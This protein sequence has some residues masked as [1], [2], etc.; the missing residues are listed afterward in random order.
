MTTETIAS[1]ELM[2]KLIE[3]LEDATK[4]T[5]ESAL[6]LETA[7]RI[8]LREKMR[9]DWHG[10]FISLSGDEM[11]LQ[12]GIASDE[13]GCQAIAG[14]LMMLEPDDDPLPDDDLAD[15]F[16]EVANLLLGFAKTRIIEDG[17]DDNL[18]MGTPLHMI[19]Q[20]RPLNGQDLICS[21]YKL[22]ETTVQLTVIYAP[23]N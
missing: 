20:F 12:M 22:G 14:A 16:G 18:I 9:P 19:G 23:K 10:A 11:Q 17:L 4:E 1:T 8:Q 13:K 7:E 15:A 3:I 2:S 6:C 5:A 21:D